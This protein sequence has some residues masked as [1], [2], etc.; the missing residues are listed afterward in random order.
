MNFWTSLGRTLFESILGIDQFANIRLAL[1]AFNTFPDLCVDI[2]HHFSFRN[3]VTTS[4]CCISKSKY[5]TAEISVSM[6]ENLAIGALVCNNC[7]HV[8]PEMLERGV[9]RLGFGYF[10]K[11]FFLLYFEDPFRCQIFH[12]IYQRSDFSHIILPICLPLSVDVHLPELQVCTGGLL[13]KRWRS[14]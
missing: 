7:L 3:R 4:I 14:L 8:F 10:H 11:W 9:V 6:E 13:P 12:S 1:I 5:A 2:F